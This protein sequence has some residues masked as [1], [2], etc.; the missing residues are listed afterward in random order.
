MGEGAIP[1]QPTGEN[2]TSEKRHT[3]HE[4]IFLSKISV[5]TSYIE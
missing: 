4:I 1:K 5:S 3:R 2:H